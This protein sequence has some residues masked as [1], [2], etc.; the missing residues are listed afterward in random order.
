MTSWPR[1]SACCTEQGLAAY[2]A[3]GTE[4]FRP[5]FLGLLAEA[6]SEVGQ[7]E[8]GLAVLTEALTLVDKTAERL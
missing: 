6:Q 8:A 3:T 5:Y 2:R 1:D 7:V 4:F